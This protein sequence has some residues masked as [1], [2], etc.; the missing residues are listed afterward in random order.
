MHAKGTLDTIDRR[1]I[2][3]SRKLVYEFDYPPSSEDCRRRQL[4]QVEVK[5][6]SV[7]ALQSS[8]E[9]VTMHA[10]PLSLTGSLIQRLA[11]WTLCSGSGWPIFCDKKHF[12]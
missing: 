12:T 9:E 4:V 2:S 3:C 5:F 8:A 1:F 6:S 10:V 7:I 11:N